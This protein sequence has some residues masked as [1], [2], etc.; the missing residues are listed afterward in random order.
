MERLNVGMNDSFD[1]ADLP[2]QSS[3]ISNGYEILDQ[4]AYFIMS[5][6][7][8]DD[9]D[10]NNYVLNKPID[11]TPLLGERNEADSKQCCCVII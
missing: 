2:S 3:Q 11:P 8:D 7:D 10:A 5:S 6:N 4:K 9:Y 1:W